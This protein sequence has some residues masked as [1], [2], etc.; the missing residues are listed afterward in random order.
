MTG[1][2]ALTVMSFR[3]GEDE[4]EYPEVATVRVSFERYWIAGK[5]ELT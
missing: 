4:S 2:R 5:L 1:R 3:I